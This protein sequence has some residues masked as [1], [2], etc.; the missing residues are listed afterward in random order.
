MDAIKGYKDLEE[1]C[2]L[3]EQMAFDRD[4]RNCQF[5]AP[6]SSPTPAD[7]RRRRRGHRGGRRVRERR[8]R[9]Q[10]AQLDEQQR[11][12]RQRAQQARL[13]E[14][15]RVERLRRRE[16]RQ[17]EQREEQQRVEVALRVV[18]A[19]LI[20]ARCLQELKR[21]HAVGPQVVQPHVY[22]LVFMAWGREPDGTA[23]EQPMVVLER[24]D[25]SAFDAVRGSRIE[26]QANNINALM[27][28]HDI[29]P[30]LNE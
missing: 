5:R 27:G 14:Q 15:Q 6:A 17:R 8:Q 18:E 23:S 25:S 16:Q 12:Q 1:W 28:P 21:L 19:R 22:W 30:P 4:P 7:N 9:M 3:Q 20:Y 2:R 11:E 24:S 13:E 26:H 29:V 10:Q